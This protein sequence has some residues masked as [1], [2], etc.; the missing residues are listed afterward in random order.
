MRFAFLV[1]AAPAHAEAGVEFMREAELLRLVA[2][3]VV[4]GAKDVDAPIVGTRHRRRAQREEEE[5]ET[6]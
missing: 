2:I 1:L 4:G 6:H 3:E 5:R